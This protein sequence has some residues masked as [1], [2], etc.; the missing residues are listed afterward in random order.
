MR[1]AVGQQAQFFHQAGYAVEHGVYLHAEPVEG[2]ARPGKRN[3][4]RQVAGANPIGNRCNLA[5]A[6]PDIVGKNQAAAKAEQPRHNQRN[7]R[8]TAAS[9]TRQIQKL[10]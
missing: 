7:Q 3:P 9:T 6:S 5:D 10:S 8:S 2:V 4:L 1:E